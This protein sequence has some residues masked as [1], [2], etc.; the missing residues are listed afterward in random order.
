MM[1]NLNAPGTELSSRYL[2]TLRKIHNVPPGREICRAE[3]DE[4]I[5][6]P[7][8]HG[9]KILHAVQVGLQ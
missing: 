9:E 2:R 6:I 4:K 5:P 3:I 1:V 8:Q 7:V